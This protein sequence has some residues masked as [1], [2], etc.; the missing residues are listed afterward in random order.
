MT[1]EILRYADEHGIDDVAELW[2]DAP[3]DSLPGSLWR[4][5]LLRHVVAADTDLAG[6]R[7]KRGLEEGSGPEHAITGAPQTPSP[8]EVLALANT[9]LAGAF[10]GDFASALER[11]AAFCHIEGLGAAALSEG[12]VANSFRGMRDELAVAAK[13]W[14]AGTLL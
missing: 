12:D 10:T 5:Y 13:S 11:A 14:R 2:A 6:Y 3:A 4:V 9:I 7:F 8:A 1:D